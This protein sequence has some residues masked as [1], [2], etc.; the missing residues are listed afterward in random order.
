MN[1]VPGPMVPRPWN[2]TGAAGRVATLEPSD[3]HELDEAVSALRAHLQAAGIPTP[4]V[5]HADAVW[6]GARLAIQALAPVLDDLD[7]EEGVLPCLDSAEEVC[8]AA[9]DLWLHPPT[10]G[11]ES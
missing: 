2:W 9:R 7:W 6:V 4:Q 11:A 5:E 8:Y 3:T 1:T 10:R